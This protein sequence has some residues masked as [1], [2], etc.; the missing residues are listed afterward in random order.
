M[1]EILLDDVGL[2]QIKQ[3]ATGI[4]HPGNESICH[5][6]KRNIIFK[7]ILGWRYV[8]SLQGITL[9]VSKYPIYFRA[10]LKN[11]RNQS[12]LIQQLS[13]RTNAIQVATQ[14]MNSI[15][16]SPREPGFFHNK[17]VVSSPPQKHV[18]Q[19]L[20][21]PIINRG[22]CVGFTRLQREIGSTFSISGN[23]IRITSCLQSQ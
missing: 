20:L 4:Y 18:L 15:Y 21:F 13:T 14:R 9:I 2:E 1:P 11:Q 17:S 3:L 6:A 23:R 19:I 10:F 22:S 8:S 12:P 5:L 7:Y 16:P